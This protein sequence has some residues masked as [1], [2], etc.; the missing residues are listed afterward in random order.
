MQLPFRHSGP[1]VTKKGKLSFPAGTTR[2]GA[3]AYKEFMVEAGLLPDEEVEE[4]RQCFG[5]GCVLPARPGSK[6]CSDDDEA[7]GMKLARAYV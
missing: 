2:A 6:Y 3:R 4:V 7:C 5:P 1:D